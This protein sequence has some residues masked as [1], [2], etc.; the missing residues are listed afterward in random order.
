MSKAVLVM[1]MPKN[2]CECQAG[3]IT[4]SYVYC[5]AKKKIAYG[6]LVE[7]YG[8]PLWCPLKPLPDKQKLTFADT[9]Q[10]AITM[11]W[12]ACIDAIEGE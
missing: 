11:G 8:K 12:N 7:A 10:D 6:E 5:I 9:G 3:Y 2:C 1:H 4:C